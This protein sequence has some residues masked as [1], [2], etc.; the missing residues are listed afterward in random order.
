MTKISR[1]SRNSVRLIAT[2]WVNNETGQ[3]T[4]YNSGQFIY[5]L[6]CALT[7]LN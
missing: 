4:C 3:I 7:M 6:Q 1:V 2:S 5:S